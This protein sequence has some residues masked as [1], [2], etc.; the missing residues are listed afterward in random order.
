[1]Q[2]TKYCAVSAHQSNSDAMK[3]TSNI[4]YSHSVASSAS[5]SSSSTATSYNASNSSVQITT[6]TAPIASALVSGVTTTKTT[7][8]KPAI[9]TPKV[10]FAPL[11]ITFPLPTT[12]TNS[13][14]CG[15]AAT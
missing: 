1:M 15:P 4:G 8:T 12:S 11:D 10:S 6:P 2:N 7:K 9:K 13:G 14:S 3:A 5:A